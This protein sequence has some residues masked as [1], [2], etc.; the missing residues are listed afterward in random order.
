M[1]LDSQPAS[2]PAPKPWDF[3]EPP[4]FAE[5]PLPQTIDL[6]PPLEPATDLPP[7]LIAVE[8]PATPASTAIAPDHTAD[9]SSDRSWLPTTAELQPARLR[10]GL[11][12][13]GS[14]AISLTLLWLYIKWVYPEFGLAEQMT[15]F[16]QP[17]IWFVG[18]GVSG[19]FMLGRGVMRAKREE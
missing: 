6:L 8:P 3:A 9:A 10:V 5:P 13:V 1:S 11:F 16:W 18:L 19:L 14:G 4:E 17:Y 15:Y 7:S 2:S 12:F